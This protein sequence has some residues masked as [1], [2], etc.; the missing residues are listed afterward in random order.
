MQSVAGI[1][2]AEWL[3]TGKYLEIEDLV[4][5]NESRSE[6][7]GSILFDWIINY[8]TENECTQ[9]R[10]A[11]GATRE[12]AHKFYLNKVLLFE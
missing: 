11:S 2:I 5:S 12:A 4:T 3:K 7:F 6:G 10:L 1:R 9:V 8:A